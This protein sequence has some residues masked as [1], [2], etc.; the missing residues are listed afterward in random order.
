[1]GDVDL[2]ELA[3]CVCPAGDF[4]DGSCFVELLEASIGIG[5]QC[6]LVELEMLA[7][8]LALAVGRVGEPDGRRGRI[9]GR[10]IIANVGPEPSSLGAAV[11]GCEHRDGRVVGVQLGCRHD[12]IA[13]S[14]DQGCEQLTGCADPAGE[15]RAVEVDAFT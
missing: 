13:H 10:S 12:V 7:W 9:S 15:R 11:A 3:P 1:M 5:L 4:N 8:V 2:V 6:A 14:L